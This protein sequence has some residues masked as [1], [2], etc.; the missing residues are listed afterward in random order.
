MRGL[1]RVRPADQTASSGRR[2]AAAT[3][4][5]ASRAG[6]RITATTHASREWVL[7]AYHWA[8]MAQP[9]DFPEQLLYATN[10]V[11]GIALP[12]GHYPAEQAADETGAELSRFFGP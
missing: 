9:Y 2:T 5:A 1:P 4:T 3:P 6:C 10:L 7:N 11:R 12:C 8:F